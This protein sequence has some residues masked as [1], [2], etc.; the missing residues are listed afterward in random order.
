MI[1]YLLDCLMYFADLFI[2]LFT[3]DR[4]P[5]KILLTDKR[6]YFGFLEVLL[7]LILQFFSMRFCGKFLTLPIWGKF[8]TSII[9]TMGVIFCLIIVVGIILTF[10]KLFK[11]LIKT[12]KG[13]KRR[14]SCD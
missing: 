12:L 9:L 6:T 1:S 8:I 13:N 4:M 3:V 5:Y 2:G 10:V 7:A 11:T 14:D